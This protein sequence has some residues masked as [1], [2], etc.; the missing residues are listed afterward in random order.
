MEK[1]QGK[2]EI[3]NKYFSDFT[4]TQMQ[5]FAALGPLYAEWNAKINVIS[6]KDIDALYE[7]HILHSLSI[8]SIFNFPAGI[9]IID[10]GTGGG[11]PGIP[12]AIYFPRCKI[13][14]SGFH[15]KKIKGSE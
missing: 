14:P 5:Q 10:I 3:I 2:L 1:A 7:K 4:A 12:L 15:R 8:A 9:E 6:R 13:P 11:F